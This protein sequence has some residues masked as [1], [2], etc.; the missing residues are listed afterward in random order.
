LGAT[1]STAT[2]D[3]DQD[4]QALDTVRLWLDSEHRLQ[5]VIDLSS[6]YYWEQDEHHRFTLFRH[7]DMTRPENDPKRFLGKVPWEMGGQPTSGTWEDHKAVREARQAFTDFVVH[8]REPGGTERYLS[9]SGKPV[10]DFEGRFQGYRGITRDITASKRAERRTWLDREL[11]RILSDA[12]DGEAL[13][14]ALRTICESER[15]DAGQYWILDEANG[16]MR[17]QVGWCLGDESIQDAMREARGLSWRPGIGLVGTVWQTGAPL[18]VCDLA[19]DPRVVRKDL[20][21]HTGWTS[22]LLFPV[23]S[24]GRIIGVL[25]F[26][27]R[28]IQEPDE[29][30]LKVVHSLGAQIGS[31]YQRAAA[32]ARL[33]ESEERYSS[34]VELAAI[35]ISHVGPNGRF[36]HVNRQLCE[37][38][39]Y[40]REELLDLTVRAISHPDDIHVTDKDAERMRSG[41]VSSFKAEKRYLRKDGTPIW[42]RIT[43]A[44]RRGPDG[45]WLHDI[46]IVEDVS[47]R[48]LAEERVQYLATHDEMTDLPNRTMFTQLLTHAIEQG[49]RYKR[50]FAVLFIDLDRFKIVNDSLGHDAGDELLKVMAA[51]L[52][53]CLRSSDV[54]ARLGGDEFVLLVE[55]LNERQAAAVVARHVLSAVIRPVVVLGQEC[56]VTASIGIATFPEDAQDPK[57]LMKNADMAMYVAKEEGKNNYQFYSSDISAVTVERMALERHLR[58]ALDRNELSLQYQAKVSLGTG[59]IRGVEALLRWRHPE[60]G[61]VPPNRF[62]PIAEESGLIVPIGTWVIG[63]ACAQGAAWLRQGLPRVRIAVNLSPRHF[64]DVN[65]VADVAGILARTG[66]PPELLELELTESMIVHDVEQ[67]VERLNAIKELGV[68]LAIDDF[69]TGYSSLAHLKRLPIDTLKVDRSFIRDLPRDVED[70]AI[71]EAIIS[72]GKTLGITVVA[73]GVETPEQQAFL[74]SRSCDEMQGF[75]FS[76]PVDT[77]EFTELLRTHAPAPP[78]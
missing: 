47:E 29:Q 8:R 66:L 41:Q 49:R 77:D 58:H 26:N 56:R 70:R 40:S 28:S 60:L 71:T 73:E 54:V 63:T 5:C 27:G 68:R 6:D 21:C 45:T 22:A 65:L 33:R 78:R 69:G 48:R 75:Y 17:S 11:T 10:F 31:F 64:R 67:A 14:A 12:T 38:L 25:D 20:A 39:G 3:R 32:L 23:V 34:T 46:S 15:W 30:L 36:I 4:S 42:V 19:K 72:I 57:N 74:S 51:R 35:G 24:C 76:R 44:P 61:S 16:V 50:R 1:T 18:W 53:G 2:V 43:V 9:I 37:M 7:R 52:R 62:I 55:E 59:E 13:T